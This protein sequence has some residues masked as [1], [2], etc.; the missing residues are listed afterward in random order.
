MMSQVLSIGC[1]ENICFFVMAKRQRFLRQVIKLLL[2]V[3][4]FKYQFVKAY[5]NLQKL[6]FF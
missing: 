2:I 6:L 1:F 5:Y 3:F 4:F